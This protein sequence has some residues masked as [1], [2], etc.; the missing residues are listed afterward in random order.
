[1]TGVQ[2]CALPIYGEQIDDI[3]GI[4]SAIDIIAEINLDRVSNWPASLV[5]VDASK[6]FHQ[7]VGATVNVAD[8]VDACVRRQGGRFRLRLNCGMCAHWWPS[9]IMELQ[10]GQMASASRR[11]GPNKAAAFFTRLRQA[12][13]GAL[14]EVF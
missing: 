10:P 9:S 3:P 4:R 7:E 13:G 6:C 5:V 1:M 12:S 2:T 8:A 14:F 11:N